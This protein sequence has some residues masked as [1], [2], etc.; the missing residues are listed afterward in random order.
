MTKP[1]VKPELIH[2]SGLRILKSYFETDLNVDD[3]PEVSHFGLGLKSESAFNLEENVVR[4][5]LYTKVKGFNESEEEM[6]VNGEYLIEFHFVVENLRDF[7][8]EDNEELEVNAALGGT[9]A[10]IAYSTSRGI[11]LDRTQSTDFKGVILPVINP[12]HLLNEDTFSE[13]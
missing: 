12:H 9:L 10:G 2:L 6:N 5:R 8:T 1:Q 3:Y 4:F 11:I 13:M 7:V